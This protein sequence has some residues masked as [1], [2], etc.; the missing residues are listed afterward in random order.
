MFA[1]LFRYAGAEACRAST[2]KQPCSFS[3]Y[4]LSA[5]SLRE[6]LSQREKQPRFPRR[7]PAQSNGFI[8]EPDMFYTP[9]AARLR[10]AAQID[11]LLFFFRHFFLS[12]HG[13][14]QNCHHCWRITQLRNVSVLL[15]SINCGQTFF[16]GQLCVCIVVQAVSYWVCSS[17]LVCIWRLNVEEEV[18]DVNI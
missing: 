11:F 1:L 15:K 16:S 8:S 4:W 10:A 17:C 13:I 5:A 12:K 2:W 9:R 3:G 6:L 7:G 18:G 14:Q